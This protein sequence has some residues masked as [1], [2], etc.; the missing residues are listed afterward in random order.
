MLGG[1]TG[2]IPRNK[3]YVLVSPD[4]FVLRKSINPLSNDAHTRINRSLAHAQFE[5]LVDT[6]CRIGIHPLI[7]NPKS[8]DPHNTTPDI[9]YTANWGISLPIPTAPFILSRMKSPYRRPES[10]KV[11]GILLSLLRTNLYE[12]PP[13]TLFEGTGLACWS[14]NM[15][16]LWIAYGV[17]TSYKDAISLKKMIIAIYRSAK[18]TPPHIHLLH[19][20]LP[21]YDLD[22]SFLSF[23]NG[24]LLYRPDAFMP[25]S[26]R[27]IEAVFGKNAHKFTIIDS[28]F[29]LNAKII[30]GHVICGTITPAA[31]RIVESIGQM[32]V[33]SCPLTYA[34]KGGGSVRCCILDHYVFV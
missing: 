16:H 17:R 12:L 24:R 1:G 23:P 32:P 25:E 18:I 14:H 4:Q 20:K 31:K 27:K 7:I 34:E 8:L 10:S 28:P 13:T 26:I 21:W 5:R 19:I 2:Y 11:A 3:Q 30:N 22:L 15:S 6:L 9:V 33:I 29:A